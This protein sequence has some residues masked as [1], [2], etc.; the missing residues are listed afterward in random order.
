MTNAPTHHSRRRRHRF[1]LAICAVLLSSACAVR[2][3]SPIQLPGCTPPP[4]LVAELPDPAEIGR[5]C[6]P[7]ADCWQGELA[8]AHAVRE[9]FFEHYDAHRAYLL[10][11]R[12]TSRGQGTDLLAGPRAEY[13]ALVA[14]HP[15]HPAYPH[16]LAQLALEGAE[17]EARLGDLGARF[18]DYPW[19][20]LS[21]AFL[22]RPD[23][24]AETL[25]RARSGL[26]RFIA[27]CPERRSEQVAA[28]ERIGD[29]ELWELHQGRLRA[30]ALASRDLADLARIWGGALRLGG[31]AGQAGVRATILSDLAELERLGVP[32]DLPALTILRASYEQIGDPA[33]VAR[34][35][36][37]LLSLHPCSRE[38]RQVR[39][40]KLAAERETASRSPDRERLAW[41]GRALAEID[42]ALERCPGDES[43]LFQRIGLLRDAP[44]ER[45][46]ELLAAV[47]RWLAL[48][49]RRIK[50]TT[51]VEE[52]V[53]ELYLE[54]RVRLD[55]V[56]GLLTAATNELDRLK[57]KASIDGASF[58]YRKRSI[59]RL[60][61]ELAILTGD[62]ER[63]RTRLAELGSAVGAS[64]GEQREVAAL[65]ARLAAFEGRGEAALEGYAALLAEEGIGTALES[66]A[67]RTW[68][69][70]RGSG[71]GFDSWRAAVSR[72]LPTASPWRT[73]DEALPAG[74][75]EGLVDLSGSPLD[76]SA[77]AG[78]VVLLRFWAPWCAPCRGEEDEL[79]TLAENLSGREE[80]VL[81]L[82]DVGWDSNELIRIL[83]TE[84]LPL[85]PFSGGRALFGKGLERIP[86]SWIVNREGRIVRRQE[87]SAESP[88]GWV[89][90]TRA[91]LEAVAGSGSPA[92]PAWYSLPEP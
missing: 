19:V 18:P 86:A 1:R 56:R 68:I 37:R 69:E 53:A 51:V 90:A 59:K 24:S 42:S 61:I 13:E 26:A 79:A 6:G 83:S 28:L 91:E 43:L 89:E 55:S 7:V 50:P 10:V 14:A 40:M 31:E 27:I 23:A 85:D 64:A 30:A 16:L 35:E 47:D 48:P 29:L 87:G 41:L 84:G 20:Q 88:A 72:A 33:G 54:R 63:A 75:L 9:R 22:A 49:E 25:A 81:A 66:E 36:E 65:E 21:L 78:K 92:T 73:V 62:A 70:T 60:E 39:S 32:E 11:L 82:V 46:A 12:A 5:R 57:E 17:Y 71:G 76:W 3:E 74:A 8:R 45:N 15:D 58:D 34:T 44:E 52:W 80:M 77:L 2:G 67:R 38:S 4:A